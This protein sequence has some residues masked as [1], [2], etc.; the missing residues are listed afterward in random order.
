M[1]EMGRKIPTSPEEWEKWG[2][3]WADE[4]VRRYEIL[5]EEKRHD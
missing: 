3:R 1:I 5:G 2:T 4:C